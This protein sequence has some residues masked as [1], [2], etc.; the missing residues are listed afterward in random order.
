MRTNT[1]LGVVRFLVIIAFTMGLVGAGLQ[2]NKC[3]SGK[4]NKQH[5]SAT[6]KKDNKALKKRALFETIVLI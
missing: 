3:S 2:E 1:I 6:L 5:E 4:C